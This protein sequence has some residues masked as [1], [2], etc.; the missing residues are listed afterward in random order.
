M[1]RSMK[2]SIGS[3]MVSSE[4][5]ELLCVCMLMEMVVAENCVGDLGMVIVT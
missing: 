3:R 4:D 2:V 1:N 5:I